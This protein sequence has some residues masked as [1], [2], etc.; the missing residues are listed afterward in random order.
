MQ[1]YIAVIQDFILQDA[2]SSSREGLSMATF[3]S[4]DSNLERPDDEKKTW[5]IAYNL[6]SHKELINN[7]GGKDQKKHYSCSCSREG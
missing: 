1:L 4:L 5:N 6:R 2:L 7:T 3:N